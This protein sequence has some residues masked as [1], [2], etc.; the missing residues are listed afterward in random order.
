MENSSTNYNQIRGWESGQNCVPRQSEE[1]HEKKK[2][3]SYWHRWLEL[4]QSSR[5]RTFQVSQR[6]SVLAVLG[7]FSLTG[8]LIQVNP[9]PPSEPS[10]A[11]PPPPAFKKSPTVKVMGQNGSLEGVHPRVKINGA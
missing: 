6:S 2:S 8:M 11:E 3:G 10:V 9:S 4:R 5:E 7:Q 1:M